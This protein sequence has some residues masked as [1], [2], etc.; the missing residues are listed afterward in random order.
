MQYRPLG[1]TGFNVSVIGFGA[2]PLGNEFGPADFDEGVRA[3]HLAIDRGINFFDV[4][5][6]YGR[7]VAEERLGRALEG[8]RD[9]VVLATKCGR[10]GREPQECDYSAAR[11]SASVD[12]SLA[13]LRTDHVDLI[14][15]HDVEN[16]DEPNRIVQETIP[17]LRK[18]QAAGKA[19]AV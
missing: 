16:V 17:A 15:V 12:E 13:R 19:R 7:T 6:Y 5:P 14:Q 8:R 9:R 11:V 10:Y 18:L 1:Q 3:V 4:S 2:S